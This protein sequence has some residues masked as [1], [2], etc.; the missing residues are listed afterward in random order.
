MAKNLT[1][2]QIHSRHSADEEH[3]LQVACVRWFRLQYP[4]YANLLFAV[5][6]GGRRDAITGARLKDEGV[7]AG[8]S[9][10]ILLKDS[11]V[12]SGEEICCWNGLCIEM[13][14]PTGRQTASQKEWGKAVTLQGYCYKVVRS[15]DEFISLIRNYLEGAFK[16]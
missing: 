7:L 14:T 1:P 8:V 10:L 12:R 15:I 9:D 4:E 3:R 5:P 2:V 11:I 16:D 6:N 13:K